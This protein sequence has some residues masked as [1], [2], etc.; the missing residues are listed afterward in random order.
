MQ[1]IDRDTHIGKLINEYLTNEDFQIPKESIH[2][3]FSAN[4]WEM[5]DIILEK[6][7]KGV[8][9]VMDRYYYSG[10]AYSSAD[11]LDF[12][13]CKSPDVGLPTPDLTLFLTFEKEK[14]VTDL[15]KRENYGEERYEKVDFQQKVKQQFGKFFTSRMLDGFKD[16]DTG[17]QNEIIYVD[18]KSIEEVHQLIFKYIEKFIEMKNDN[19]IQIFK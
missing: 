11:G 8:T 15:Q 18:D 13:W 17:S 4:R 16:R 2:L 6:L 14:S 7:Y 19:P 10:I 3:L 5:K 12:D 1:H 9:V